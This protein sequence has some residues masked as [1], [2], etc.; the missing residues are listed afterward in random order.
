[1]AHTNSTRKPKRSKMRVSISLPREQ[2]DELTRI[3]A[4]NRTSLAWA[5]RA[6][7]EHYLQHETPLFHLE[8]VTN[9]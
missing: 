7:V 8:K 2:Y 1:M 9:G 6:A 5:V 3:A 4:T